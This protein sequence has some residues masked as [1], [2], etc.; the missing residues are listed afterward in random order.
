[1]MLLELTTT[2][3]NPARL[4]LPVAESANSVLSVLSSS[5][6]HENAY[7]EDTI[8]NSVC[9]VRQGSLIQF[10]NHQVSFPEL[11]VVVVVAA[12]TV[13]AATTITTITASTTTTTTTT[14]CFGKET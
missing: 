5:R 2:E 1:M 8:D 4:V 11:L 12:V 6:V 13:V 10:R 9:K 14:T 3:L 7:I